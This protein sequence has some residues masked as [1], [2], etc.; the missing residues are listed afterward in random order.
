MLEIVKEFVN[1]FAVTEYVG[2]IVGIVFSIATFYSF[3]S[4][5]LKEEKNEIIEKHI[6]T[7]ESINAYIKD[8][9]NQIHYNPSL[10]KLLLFDVL[11]F[12]NKYLGDLKLFSFKSFSKHYVISFIYSF[13]FFYF[14]WLV[15]ANGEIG[16][17]RFIE[18]IEDRSFITFL[19]IIE[20]IIV[21]ILIRN[22]KKIKIYTSLNEKNIS[23][24]FNFILIVNLIVFS[25][26]YGVYF[27]L[28]IFISFGIFGIVILITISLR[29]TVSPFSKVLMIGL[30]VIAVVGLLLMAWYHSIMFIEIILKEDLV[31]NSQVIGITETS[32]VVFLFAIVL[33][34]INAI[35]DY[36]SMY[37]SRFFAHEIL[38]TYSKFKIFLDAL[39]DLIVAVILFYLLAETLFYV[40][41]LTN[42]YLIKEKA[43]FVPI[44]T[45]KTQLL[46]NPFNKDVLWITLMFI[47]TLIPTFLHLFLATY[48]LMA[49]WL[50]KPHL[51]YLVE[52]LNNLKPNDPD[53]FKKDKI[54]KHLV[55]YR[56]G[57]MIKVYLFIGT[58][59]LILLGTVVL[60]LLL[61][62][63]LYV[64]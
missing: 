49:Y 44:E 40:V 60:M 56:L 23:L 45:Y 3:V 26:I 34:F 30:G 9:D 20:L 28:I 5:R 11:D 51:H 50:T 2:A 7:K 6:F 48:T 24:L 8:I 18:N 47:S 1:D 37:F 36:V 61:K 17:L 29:E 33:P 22:L 38:K 58:L 10:Y 16:T 15:G 62:K 31:I 42:V 12:L 54:A 35:F 59:L 4:N 41:D 19:I 21:Y 39:L 32:V 14:G 57:S 43:L 64:L 55:S 63:G 53:Y 46:V 25:F 52:E 13:L 27:G